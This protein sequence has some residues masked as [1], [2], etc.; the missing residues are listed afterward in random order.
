MVFCTGAFEV[1]LS[2]RSGTLYVSPPTVSGKIVSVCISLQCTAM[3]AKVLVS[4]RSGR[5]RE[6]RAERTLVST[7]LRNVGVNSCQRHMRSLCSPECKKANA[8]RWLRPCQDTDAV[9]G[10]SNISWSSTA[11]LD[12]CS[13]ISPLFP[14]SL[15]CSC[16]ELWARD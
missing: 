6:R 15:L 3:W 12:L 11:L 14:C 13:H 2:S 10:Q 9:W 1:Q 8:V 5:E 4:E 16:F 7:L